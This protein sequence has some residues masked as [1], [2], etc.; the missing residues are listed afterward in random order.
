V[1]GQQ[2]TEIQ[3]QL[4]SKE[5]EVRQ[6][7]EQISRLE[8]NLAEQRSQAIDERKMSGEEKRRLE[9]DL[10][11]Q[12][13]ANKQLSHDLNQARTELR[14]MNQQLELS[15][16]KQEADQRQLQAAQRSLEENGQAVLN[17]ERE[18]AGL[19]SELEEKE[20]RLGV[21]G[22]T[23][24]RL[25]EQAD[26]YRRQLDG[27]QKEITTERSSLQAD[28]AGREKKISELSGK[29]SVTQQD[30][31]E[32][33]ASL[34]KLNPEL[35]REHMLLEQ[36]Q[37]ELEH[38]RRDARQKEAEV[39]GLRASQQEGLEEIQRQREQIAQ[40]QAEVADYKSEL[41]EL[42]SSQSAME[43][44]LAAVQY[45]GPSIEILDPPLALTRGIPSVRLRSAAK[46]RLITGKVTAPAGLLSFTIND[47]V[48]EIDE[49]GT[50]K[51]AITVDKEQTSVKMVAVDKA[52]QQATIEFL[53]IPK[54]RHIKSG[55]ESA[56]GGG[57][58]SRSARSFGSIDFGSYH[59]LVIGNNQYKHF[60]SLRS[61]VQDARQ[62]AD[63]LSHKYGFQTTTL[64]DA[65]RYDMLS[66]LNTLRE[67][68]TK[69]DNLLIYYAGHGELDRVNL[70]GHWLPVDAEPNNTANWISNTAVTDILN[71]TSAKHV[72]VVADS[73]YSGSL[74]RSSLARLDAEMSDEVSARWLK[75][76]AKTRSRTVLTSGGLQPVLDEGDGRHSVFANAF[77][78]VLDQNDSILEA[79]KLYR[80][81]AK[82]VQ[83]S[84]AEFGVDQIPEY[85]P[86]RHG[87]HEAGEFFFIPQ[88]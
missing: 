25:R 74:T 36:A 69:K 17:R 18:V 61:A 79:Y 71:T 82:E 58:S 22:A 40:Y 81:L 1:D 80:G 76:M 26:L 31:A 44:S 64:I 83:Q 9:S 43:A 50:F 52:S 33:Q 60:P 67:R 14:R 75:V 34:T 12:V 15:R 54:L 45:P 2:I 41:S 37:Q 62:A 10:Q 85:A 11:A 78:R 56:A 30:L 21:Q 46:Q 66:A 68:L 28:V 5:R 57:G 86:I 38:A 63:I 72:L 13:D 32:S 73:C 27:L 35:A 77:L 51:T 23:A 88:G 24:A 70:R 48:A 55:G 53:L 49:L 59:A 8:S 20:S 29:L 7:R 4:T 6:Q 84:A 3:S 87:G 16:S 65:T 19:R 42:K 47:K 39:T